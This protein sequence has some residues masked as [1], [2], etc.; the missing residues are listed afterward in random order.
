MRDVE[1]CCD[2][3]LHLVQQGLAN[4]DKLIIKG[5]SAGGFTVLCALTFHEVFSAGASY[6]GIGNLKSLL[7][8]THKFESRYLDKLIGSYEINPELYDDRSP[9]KHTDQLNCPVIILQGAEDKV[10]PREQALSMYES[11]LNKGIA[12]TLLEFEGEQHG[13]R[14]AETIRTAIES[15]LSFYASVLDIKCHNCIDIKIDNF[16]AH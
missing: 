15:E 13:F 2:A 3:A 4:P 5:S 12:V 14:K 10:V 11:L 9:I 7:S 1:D 8:D 16:F 6:Y